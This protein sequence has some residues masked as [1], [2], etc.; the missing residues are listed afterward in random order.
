MRRKFLARTKQTDNA[1]GSLLH[2]LVG[3]GKLRRSVVANAIH[4]DSRLRWP[5]AKTMSINSARDFVPDAGQMSLL[6]RVKLAVWFCTWSHARWPVVKV[7]PV[8]RTVHGICPEDILRITA[9][10]NALAAIVATTHLSQAA[11]LRAVL[12]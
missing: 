10:I 12:E 2:V 9:G 4:K 1:V 5:D 3:A 7:A 8:A 6:I 11:K